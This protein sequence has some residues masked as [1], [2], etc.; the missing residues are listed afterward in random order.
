MRVNVRHS[1][2]RGAFD[3]HDRAM[4]TLR[5]PGGL[6][7]EASVRQ[8]DGQIRV[9]LALDQHTAVNQIVADVEAHHL[10]V[11]RLTSLNKVQ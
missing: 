10:H 2:G 3:Q 6:E 11:E 9:R 8:R 7:K 1:N 4:R 5:Q